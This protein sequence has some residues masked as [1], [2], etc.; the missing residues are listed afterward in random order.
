MITKKKVKPI[1]LKSFDIGQVRNG[2][3]VSFY[4]THFM[5][6]SEWHEYVFTNKEELI[7]WLWNNVEAHG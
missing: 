1:N 6:D 3:K 4:E 7:D 5:G 2:W